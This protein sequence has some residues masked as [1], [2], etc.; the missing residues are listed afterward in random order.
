MDQTES[1]ESPIS[2]IFGGTL[3]SVL[4]CPG[5]KD[6]AVLDPFKSLPLDIQPQN[7]RT[8]EDA[9]HNLTVPE[10]MHDYVS[11]KGVH[12]A[13]KQL[14][15]EAL[16]PVLL[17]HLK[18]FIYDVGGVQKLHKHV[19]YSIELSIIPEWIASTRRSAAL[20]YKLFGGG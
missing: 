11:P 2:K 12:D 8:L 20:K 5:S 18:R 13:T 15:L 1:V 19:G 10:V 7:V 14:Y 17:V 16:P 6:S 9:L 3:R 4:K